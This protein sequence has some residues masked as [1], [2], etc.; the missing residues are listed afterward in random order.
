MA[1][2]FHSITALISS[3]AGG[4]NV[5][6]GQDVLV[7]IKSTGLPADL[8]KEEAGTTA[9]TNPLPT[10]TCGIAEFWVE[11]GEFI[12]ESGTIPNVKT[13]FV[14]IGSEVNAEIVDTLVSTAVD[15][16]LSAN[17]GRVLKNLADTKI[18]TSNIVDNLTSTDTDKP[19]SANQGKIVKDLVDTKLDIIL[20]INAQTGTTYTIL[21]A[22]NGRMVTFDNAAAITVTVP[23]G[24]GA[25]FNCE[26]QGIG[27]GIPFL[28]ASGVTFNHPDGFFTARKR[29]SLFSIQSNV[30]DV[31]TLGGD[32]A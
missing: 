20:D 15:K 29:F 8:F 22:D 16:S 3:D 25:G 23:A 10:N 4:A 28:S 12:I 26:F 27:V 19:L 18:N 1:L 11:Q 7:K 17:Q 32:L 24:L 31:F 13:E 9:L 2:A 6:V 14:T 30:A 5:V 21:A